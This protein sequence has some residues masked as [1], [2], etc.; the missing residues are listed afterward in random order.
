MIPQGFCPVNTFGHLFYLGGASSR[1]LSLSYDYLSFSLAILPFRHQPPGPRA[2]NP[3]GPPAAGRRAAPPGRVLSPGRTAPPLPWGDRTAS[4]GR[5]K[6]P[7]R[8]GHSRRSPSASSPAV[9]V[10]SLFMF[11]LLP[12]TTC[13]HDNFTTDFFIIKMICHAFI[14][15]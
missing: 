1:I 8:P 7:S 6:S 15:L 13:I 10:G 5:H 12:S 14:S 4:A 3:A 11:A 2:R 9:G